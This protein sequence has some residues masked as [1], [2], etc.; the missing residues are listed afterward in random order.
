MNHWPSEFRTFKDEKTGRAI[1]QLTTT[2]NNVHLYFTENSFDRD[3]NEIIFLSD[4][5][6]GEDRAPHEDPQY[7]VFRMSLDTGE[8]ERLSDDVVHGSGS[9]TKTP[10]SAL[11]AYTTVD[12][13]VRLLDTHTGAQTTLYEGVPGFELSSVPS[14]ASNRRYVAFCRNEVTEQDVHYRGANYAGF[15]ERFIQ[16]KDGRVTVAYTDG[17]GWHDVFQD[18]HQ[19]GHFQFSPDDPTVGMFCHEGPWNMVRQRI[20]L[21]DFIS[22]RARPCFRQGEDDTI[23]HEF[24]TQDGLVFFDDRG[25]GHDGTITSHRT[26]AVVTDVP[27][28]QNTLIPFVGLIDRHNRLVRKI[29]MPYYCNHYHA[30]PDNTVLVGDDVDHLVLIDI[31][32]DQA[33]LETLCAH[34]TSWHTQSSHCHPTWSWDGSRILYASDRGGRVQLYLIER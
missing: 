10:D 14:I 19:L 16:I 25:P 23:G 31:S 2:G 12:G 5:A 30:N 24:W 28:N 21:L 20:W 29:D 22:R 6:S 3:R 33:Q 9:T 15:K 7:S 13:R 18:T 11:V 34:G 4:R 17:S 8:M 1:T 27:V 32:G 26:Q